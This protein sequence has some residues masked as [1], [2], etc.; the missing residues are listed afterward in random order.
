LYSTIVFGDFFP[1]IVSK[2]SVNNSFIPKILNTR[3]L[4]Y[5]DL[6]EDINTHLLESECMA[7]SFNRFS[8]RRPVPFCCKN[9]SAINNKAV[10]GTACLRVRGS[11]SS[12]Q[13]IRYTNE[14]QDDSQIDKKICK[15]Q[16]ILK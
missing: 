2:C 1:K 14:T 5:T 6:E 10:V 16:I 9:D 3:N 8:D 15:T 4:D 11:E 12:Q 7:Y 13:L